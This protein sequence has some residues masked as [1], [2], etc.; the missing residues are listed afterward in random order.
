LDAR[1]GPGVAV[2]GMAVNALWPGLGPTTSC[3]SFCR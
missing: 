2:N 3:R 1:A